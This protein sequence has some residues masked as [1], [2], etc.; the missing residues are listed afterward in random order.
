[1]K[2]FTFVIL[3]LYSSIIL[4]KEPLK[5]CTFNGK[6]LFGNVRI[7]FGDEPADVKVRVV[8]ESA[9]L[10]VWKL[11]KSKVPGNPWIY[12]CG[13]WSYVKTG[14]QF[15]VKFVSKDED[16]TVQFV[17]ADDYRG[18]TY[19]E[20]SPKPEPPPAPPCDL[21]HCCLKGI[22]LY[23]RV[24]VVKALAT[25]EVKVVSGLADLDVR[26]VAYTPG[27]C[28]EWQFVDALEDFSIEFVDALEDFS[29]EF[30]DALPGVN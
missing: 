19:L 29:I 21:K 2:Q 11:D 7:V 26:K 14:D 22:P 15:T 25:F 10:K 4:A 9:D 18:L 23:G 20:P 6:S 30:V 8:N 12:T 27:R 13:C 1:M 5:T 16:F 3:L 24:K 17:D 28:G